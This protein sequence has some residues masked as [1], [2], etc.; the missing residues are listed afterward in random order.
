MTELHRTCQAVGIYTLVNGEMKAIFLD[1]RHV[2]GHSG[3]WIARDLLECCADTLHMDAKAMI[4]QCSSF[5]F[6]G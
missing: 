5:A 4:G 1:Y 3:E 2:K 6:D